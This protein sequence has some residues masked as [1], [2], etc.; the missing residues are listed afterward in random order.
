MRANEFRNIYCGG[1]DAAEHAIHFWVGSRDTL[2]EN[3]LIADCARGIGFGLGQ[4]GNGFGRDYDDQPCPTATGYV[5]H[6]GGVIRNNVVWGDVADFDTGIGLEQAC[7]SRVWHNTVVATAA[8]KSYFS[9]IDYR[10]E[11]TVADIRNN[12]TRS[13]TLRDG[14]VGTSKAN[15]ETTSLDAFANP[16]GLDF[17]LVVQATDAID[18]GIVV[19]DSGL[20]IDGQP[21]DVGAPDIGADEFQP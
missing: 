13:I 12:Y 2:V 19:D 8:A 14:A 20:D 4:T 11:N 6:Y 16:D 9:S 17:H 1:N 7:D 3:N 21:H 18:Q 15:V 5:G 10:W